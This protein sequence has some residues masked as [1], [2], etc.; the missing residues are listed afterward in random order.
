MCISENNGKFR[1]YI[2]QEKVEKK[3][4]I[5]KRHIAEGMSYETES[6]FLFIFTIT[7]NHT[8]G[9]WDWQKRR[10]DEFVEFQHFL[11]KNAYIFSL[12]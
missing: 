5:M 8:A 12:K 2:S 1:K 7:C 9:N 3:N 10:K 11:G 4:K 6:D